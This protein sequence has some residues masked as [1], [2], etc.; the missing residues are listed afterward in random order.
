MALTNEE[1]NR[2][3]ELLDRFLCDMS[4]EE[5]A[6]I[7]GRY[8]FVHDSIRNPQKISDW[9]KENNIDID[10]LKKDNGYMFLLPQ[11]YEDYA[12]YAEFSS[13]RGDFE[14]YFSEE[15]YKNADRTG[16]ILAG[17]KQVMAIPQP[18]SKEGDKENERLNAGL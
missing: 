6:T 18:M 12:K 15:A 16:T 8:A 7:A 13:E 3:Y 4:A 11:Y 1:M 14:K 10:I 9:A 5:V 2:A 17:P